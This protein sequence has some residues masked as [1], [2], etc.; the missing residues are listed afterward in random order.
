MIIVKGLSLF[1]PIEL[2]VKNRLSPCEYYTGRFLNYKYVFLWSCELHHA[3]DF[4]MS[5]LAK[6][7]SRVLR[8]STSSRVDTPCSCWHSWS[9]CS[10]SW[11]SPEMFKYAFI[12]SPIW[13]GQKVAQMLNLLKYSTRDSWA[14]HLGSNSTACNDT[15]HI[16]K[17]NNSIFLP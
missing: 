8:W 10:A 5:R 1:W 14:C 17:G 12:I 6:S 9:S 15:S 16:E 7:V 3:C 13:R 4:F 11:C 2:R